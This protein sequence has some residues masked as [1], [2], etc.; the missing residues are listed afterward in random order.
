MSTPVTVLR[1]LEYYRLSVMRTPS[2]ILAIFTF[3]LLFILRGCT[4][5]YKAAI[6][7]IEMSL[8]YA[9]F[10]TGPVFYKG[11]RMSLFHSS[12]MAESV[13]KTY[14][15]SHYESYVKNIIDFLSQIEL[16]F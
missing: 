4:V 9:P 10:S 15:S 13:I 3:L 1:T 16:S 7:I 12:F 8:I 5:F 6:M 14:S 11:V 2:F